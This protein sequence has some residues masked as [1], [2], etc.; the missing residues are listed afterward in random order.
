[1]GGQCADDP[2]LADLRHS[3][4]TLGRL[5]AGW[6][7]DESLFA[8]A[9]C[10]ECWAVTRHDEA[11]VYQFVGHVAHPGR[12]SLIIAT[13][14]AIDPDAGWALLAGNRWLRIAKA[15]P[16]TSPPDRSEVARCS[17]A[18]LLQEIRRLKPD[19]AAC[20]GPW[21]TG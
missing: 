7:P 8:D 20:A 5:Q 4:A 18:W 14:L 21:A 11:M 9:R 17:Q 1:V 2:G 15:L 3:L 6:Q 16:T 13:V 10:A 19:T 12:T